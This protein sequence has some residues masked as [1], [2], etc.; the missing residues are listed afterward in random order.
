MAS[1][2]PEPPGEDAADAAT[3]LEPM[4]GRRRRW[5]RRTL[6]GVSI[7]VVI[8]LILGGAAWFYLGYRLNQIPR[9]AVKHLVTEKPNGAPINILL[10]GSDSRAFVGN[11]KKLQQQNGNPAVQTGQR[12]DV[13]IIVRLAPKTK[14]IEMLSIPR[15]TWV[16]IPGTGGS[17]RINASFNSGPSGLVSAIEQDFHIPINHYVEANFPGFSNVVSALH[18]VY[19]DFPDRV[20]DNNSG[21]HIRKTG[22]Q[23]VTGGQALALVRSRDLYYY[24]HGQWHY[25]GNG[26]FSRIRRQQAFFHAVIRRAN[27]EITNPIAISNF[28]GAATHDL[29]VDKSFSSSEIRN[30][31]LGFRGVAA[32]SLLTEVM[33]TREAVYNGSDILLPDPKLDTRMVAKFLAFGSPRQKKSSKATSSTTAPTTTSLAVTGTTSVPVIDNAKNY[34]EPWNPTAC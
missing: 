28:L 25:D 10:V 14:G 29:V 19:L 26:D 7:L 13:I 8:A 6:I 16:P 11:N 24:S 31:G 33:P 9:V 21:L 5:P 17:N 22:C 3:S 30:L 4:K 20:K 2:N 32:G 15:D 23:L 18:G 27:S 1:V 34:P 12:S